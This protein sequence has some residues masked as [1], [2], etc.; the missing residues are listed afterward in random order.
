MWGGRLPYARPYLEWE[1]AVLQTRQDPLRFNKV[2]VEWLPIAAIAAVVLEPICSTAA[3][4]QPVY[5]VNV[6]RTTA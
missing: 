1:A 5:D 3:Y 6:A 4:R 2:L